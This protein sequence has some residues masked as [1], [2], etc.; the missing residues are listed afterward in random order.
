MVFSQQRK[1]GTVFH[2]N[3]EAEQYMSQIKVVELSPLVWIGSV[4]SDGNSVLQTLQNGKFCTNHYSLNPFTGF[5][6]S[7]QKINY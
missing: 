1:I 2:S 4:I 7:K 3:R 5:H 6:L